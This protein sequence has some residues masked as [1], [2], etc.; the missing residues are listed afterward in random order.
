MTFDDYLGE[1]PG[2]YGDTINV[3]T[4]SEIH[5]G[6]LVLT[7]APKVCVHPTA[8]DLERP[9]HALRGL[10]MVICVLV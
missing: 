5:Y 4:D 6:P 2:L 1:V 10:G 3:D 9:T 7:V 8:H